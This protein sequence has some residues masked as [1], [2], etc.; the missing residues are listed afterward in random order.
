[1]AS[2]KQKL[3]NFYQKL[4]A[5]K[6]HLWSHCLAFYSLVIIIF[7]IKICSTKD[8]IDNLFN[9][10]L[11]CAIF[12]YLVIISIFIFFIIEEGCFPHFKIKWKLLLTNKIYHFFWLSG[13]II[14]TG[15][16]ICTVLS[17]IY[18]PL[19]NLLYK[20]IY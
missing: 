13:I 3:N 5:T 16:C 14:S 1:M 10:L 4:C 17:P 11:L 15:I 19:V 18:L 6:V 8:S 9:G 2:I 20:L 12:T 7:L